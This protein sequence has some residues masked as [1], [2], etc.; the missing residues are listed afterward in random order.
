MSGYSEEHLRTKLL[1]GLEADLV[2]V[3]DASDGCGGKFE[4]VIGEEGIL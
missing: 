3:V 4:V 2:E 1:A